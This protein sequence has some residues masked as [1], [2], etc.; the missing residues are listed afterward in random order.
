MDPVQILGKNLTISDMD[1][2][3]HRKEQC[4]EFC[5]K[6]MTGSI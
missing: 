1:L 5:S 4:T 6:G 2:T 3:V